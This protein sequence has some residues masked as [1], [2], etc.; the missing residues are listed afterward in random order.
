MIRDREKYKSYS[1]AAIE[2]SAGQCSRSALLTK[3]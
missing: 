3:T 1:D 2:D